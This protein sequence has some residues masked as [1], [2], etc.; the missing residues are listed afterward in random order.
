MAKL[1]SRVRLKRDPGETWRD[2]VSRLSQDNYAAVRDFDLQVL[3]GYTEKKA[4]FDALT[5]WGF[6]VSTAY[7]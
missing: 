7:D 2:T 6:K 5:A 1:G 4:A 3:S